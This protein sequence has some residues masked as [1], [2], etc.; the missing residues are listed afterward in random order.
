MIWKN[1]GR[2]FWSDS[3]SGKHP[4]LRIASESLQTGPSNTPVS[5]LSHI[6][7]PLRIIQSLSQVTAMRQWN[8]S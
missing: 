8:E 7:P 4:S 1:P 5:Q 2:T 6:D 3:K